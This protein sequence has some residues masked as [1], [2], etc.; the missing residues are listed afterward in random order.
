MRE[1]ELIMDNEL[2]LGLELQ[3]GL[4]LLVGLELSL[5]PPAREVGLHGVHG[6]VDAVAEGLAAR[7]LAVVAVGELSAVALHVGDGGAD[8]VGRV[9]RFS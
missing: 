8:L 4:E 3:L 5:R 9:L 7:Q 6:L 2:L 1:L